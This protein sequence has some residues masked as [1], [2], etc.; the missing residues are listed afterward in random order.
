MMQSEIYIACDCYAIMYTEKNTS[1]Y[2]MKQ[3]A[4]E[5]K[6]KVKFSNACI[7]YRLLYRWTSSYI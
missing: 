2:T 4:F 1:R 5:K 3:R 6:T 7:W